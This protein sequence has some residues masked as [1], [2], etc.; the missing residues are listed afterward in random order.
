[1]GKSKSGVLDIIEWT[2]DSK[3]YNG[4]EVPQV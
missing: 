1:M 4:L 2:D 3:R